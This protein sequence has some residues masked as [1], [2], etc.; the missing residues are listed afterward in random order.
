MEFDDEIPD[1]VQ[2]AVEES[3]DMLTPVSRHL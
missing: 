3:Y 1:V 2:V